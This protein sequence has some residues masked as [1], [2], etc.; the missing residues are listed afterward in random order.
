MA[1]EDKI[2]KPAEENIPAAENPR[3]KDSFDVPVEKSPWLIY[4]LLQIP[5]VIIMVI[6][7]YV[8][9]TQSQH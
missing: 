4:S 2:E 7:L 8:L 9:Y 1:D 3:K 6:I 5:L